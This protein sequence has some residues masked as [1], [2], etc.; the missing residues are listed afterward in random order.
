MVESALV[1][2]RCVYRDRQK[3][4]KKIKI[5]FTCR[6]GGRCHKRALLSTLSVRSLKDKNTF[7]ATC[8][9]FAHV[10]DKLAT[11]AAKIKRRIE[12]N[13][14]IVIQKAYQKQLPNPTYQTL[15]SLRNLMQ[16][17]ATPVAT[18]DE[19]QKGDVIVIIPANTLFSRWKAQGYIMN[20][21]YASAQQR[22]VKGDKLELDED[23]PITYESNTLTAKMILERIATGGGDTQYPCASDCVLDARQFDDFVAAIHQGRVCKIDSSRRAIHDAFINVLD[24]HKKIRNPTMRYLN[25]AFN[26]NRVSHDL[27]DR[28][29]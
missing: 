5:E 12:E 26:C 4:P 2:A 18:V 9:S 15:D 16:C 14:V 7:S 17:I 6:R 23:A 29:L 10:A 21:E 28:N 19:L 22:I 25:Y 1:N 8:L 3:R 13:A 11:Y 20:V 27:L 24:Y